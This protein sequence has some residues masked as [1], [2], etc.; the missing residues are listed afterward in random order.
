MRAIITAAY[1]EKYG[2][3]DSWLPSLRYLREQK[4]TAFTAGW[5]A[6][7]EWQAEQDAMSK[8]HQEQVQEEARLAGG[9]G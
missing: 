9:L 8:D 5:H 6:C 2:E 1:E 3:T 4:Q 7:E